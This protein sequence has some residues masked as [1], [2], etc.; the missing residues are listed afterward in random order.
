M[1]RFVA[2]VRAA[3]YGHAVFPSLISVR[4]LPA[5]CV[6]SV[7]DVILVRS[8]IWSASKDLI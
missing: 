1:S 7:M 5:V 6:G 4:T 8:S 3:K 2:G